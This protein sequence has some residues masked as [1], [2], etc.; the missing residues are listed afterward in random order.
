MR[1]AASAKRPRGRSRKVVNQLSRTLDSNGPD[2]KIRGTAAHI[3][4][5]Y[6]TLARDANSAGDRVMAENY[7]QHAEHYLRLINA[8]QGPTQVASASAQPSV[9][10]PR[11]VEPAVPANGAPANGANGRETPAPR[12][13]GRSSQATTA[14]AGDDAAPAQPA[15]KTRGRRRVT[16]AKAAAPEPA[17][18]EL[19]FSD[20]DAEEARA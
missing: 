5:K 14:E 12:S 3:Y 6:Q 9:D 10:A 1:Q 4:E 7:L 16:A 17:N 2:V 8:L 18:P 15:P 13:N 11:A 20:K 19:P